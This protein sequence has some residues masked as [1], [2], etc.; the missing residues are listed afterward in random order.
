MTMA[1]AAGLRECPNKGKPGCLG[2]IEIGSHCFKCRFCR[3][4]QPCSLVLPCRICEAKILRNA[5]EVK[6]GA[7]KAASQAVSRES[8]GDTPLSKRTR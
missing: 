8:S 1:P 2:V 3:G 7:A 4:N 5:A 6:L